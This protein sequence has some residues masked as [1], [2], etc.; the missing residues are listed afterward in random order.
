MLV[1]GRLELEFAGGVSPPRPVKR[2][3]FRPV[4]LTRFETSVGQPLNGSTGTSG[5]TQADGLTQ[6]RERSRCRQRRNLW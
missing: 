5:F 6:Q 3:S 1:A 4:C 2:S